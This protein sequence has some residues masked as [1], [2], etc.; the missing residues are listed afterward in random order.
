MERKRKEE[1]VKILQNEL[2]TAKNVFLVNF[3][4]LNV[5]KDQV[6]RRNLREIESSYRVV[7]NNLILR[8]IPGTPLEELNEYFSGPT[9]I[10]YTEN[11]PVELA[12]VLTNFSKDHGVLE[13]KVGL[14]EGKF[15]GIEDI[16]LLA[17]L[18][19]REE[20]L[21]RLV[22]LLQSPIQRLVVALQDTLGKFVRVLGQIRVQK[23]DSTS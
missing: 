19:T 22:F 2:K 4:G 17:T 9:A 1:I 18:P 12:R 13:L 6:L 10:A 20:L 15:I 23:E 16:R 11:H 7:K 21:T 3:T 8:A 5:E 14:V